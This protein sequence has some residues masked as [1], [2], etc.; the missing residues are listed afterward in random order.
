MLRGGPDNLSATYRA[1]MS[2]EVEQSGISP[3]SLRRRQVHR[4]RKVSEKLSEKEGVATGINGGCTGTWLKGLQAEEDASHACSQ[5]TCSCERPDTGDLDQNGNENGS[6]LHD[7]LESLKLWAGGERLCAVCQEPFEVPS[8]GSLRQFLAAE[9]PTSGTSPKE[10]GNGGAA[11][12]NMTA[13]NVEYA[14]RQC[15]CLSCKD[16]FFRQSGEGLSQAKAKEFLQALPAVMRS[17]A[18]L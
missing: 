14:S 2:Y 18:F 6:T 1:V 11:P 13:G 9:S 7:S 8:P 10:L 4:D 3:E 5:E 12:I 16:S 17:R 15:F